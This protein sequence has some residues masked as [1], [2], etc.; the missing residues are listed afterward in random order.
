MICGYFLKDE[1]REE[2]TSLV[3]DGKAET[4]VTRRANALLLLDKGWSCERVADA[5]FM[6]DDTIRYWH[7]LW[8]DRGFE[9]LMEFGYKGQACALTVAQQEALKRWVSDTLPRTTASVGEWIEKHCGVS[10]TRS[11]IIKLLKRL[12]MEYRKP[13]ALPRKLDPAK[14]EAFIKEYND[15]LNNMADDEV[16]LF[17]DAVHPTYEARP[18][19]CWA[20]KDQKI[21]V[22]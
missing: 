15:L 18:A 9:W 8:L 2:L 13:K 12:G 4:R 5:L 6:D 17:A 20:P 16:V 10:Y 14:Q 1:E 22:E 21:V 7:K 19:G 11:A 3:R